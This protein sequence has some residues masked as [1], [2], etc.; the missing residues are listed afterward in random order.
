MSSDTFERQ[1][2]HYL[3]GF[4]CSIALSIVSFFVVLSGGLGSMMITMAFI[5]FLAG[6]QVYIQAKYFLHVS[7]SAAAF[8]RSSMLI[9]TILMMLIVVLGSVWI[10]KNLDYRMGMSS[11]S[12]TE[13]MKAQN[14]K[15]F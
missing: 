1:V 12:M 10:M 2:A 5:L 9:Y 4:G 3:I 13:Y 8:S 15:G 7:F 6:V 11:E 14:K